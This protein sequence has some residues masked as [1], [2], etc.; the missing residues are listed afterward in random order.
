VS[1]IQTC[2]FACDRKTCENESPAESNFTEA[3]KSALVAGWVLHPS[4]GPT[5]KHICPG[6]AQKML[7]RLDDL[8]DD[9]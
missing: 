6:C 5:Q 3:R 2:S 9:E 1:R 7:T 4:S 8:E